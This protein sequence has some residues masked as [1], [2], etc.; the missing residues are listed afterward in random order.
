MNRGVEF[1]VTLLPFAWLLAGFIV[2][3]LDALLNSALAWLLE[4]GL[5]LVFYDMPLVKCIQAS[6]W[7]SL[8]MWT[9]FL[10]LYTGQIFGQAYR[11][12]GLLQVLLDSVQSI[13]PPDDQRGRAAALTGVIGGFIG[14]FNGFA[15]YPVTVPGLTALGFGGVDAVVAYLVYFSWQEALVSLFIAANISNAATHVPVADIAHVIGWFTI[16]LIF[17]CLLGFFKVLGFAF[18]ERRT[19]TLFWTLGL[20]NTAAVVLFTQ[21]WPS[22][23]I[24]TLIA[25]AAF[26]LVALY[27]DGR[28]VRRRLAASAGAAPAAAAGWCRHSMMH[29]MKAYA[30]LILGALFVFLTMAPGIA[31]ALAYFQFEVSAWGNRPVAINILTSAGFVVLLTGLFCYCFRVKDSKILS[32]LVVASRR[33]G[34]SLATLFVG[35]GMVRL[36]VD[37]GQ[38]SFLGKALAGGGR[39]VYATLDPVLALL[40]G[41]AFGQ[42]LPADYLFAQMQVSVA[43]MLGLSLVVLVGMVTVATMGPPNGLKPA[44]IKYTASLANVKGQDA[45]I[46]RRSLPWQLLQVA[47]L[48]LLSAVIVVMWRPA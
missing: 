13:L 32:D 20:C 2:F 19:Q 16:P 31:P 14:T 40:G 22:L 28:L 29:R 4:L 10:V 38:I 30:P 44:I 48:A 11:A 43:P 18:F 41:I 1:I 7:G 42:G 15:T 8:T 39:L 12:T 6:L 21:I 47:A 24:L 34:G 45:V 17:I 35:S 3:R 25:S 23:Y 36:M 37:S 26:S 33:S 46:F 5:V 27:V 9:G